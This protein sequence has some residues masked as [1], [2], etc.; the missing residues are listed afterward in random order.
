[1]LVLTKITYDEIHCDEIEHFIT[2]EDAIGGGKGV[3]G[4]KGEIG[5]QGKSRF[6]KKT[7]LRTHDNLEK[8]MVSKYDFFRYYDQ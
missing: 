4:P 2:G 7:L 3:P 8:V 6:R 5:P 1:M